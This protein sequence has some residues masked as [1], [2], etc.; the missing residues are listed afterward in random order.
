M[1]SDYRKLTKLLCNG[2]INA[3]TLFVLGGGFRPPSWFF[4]DSE[5]LAQAEGLRVFD[6]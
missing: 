2:F 5:K 6:F 1:S 4:K 3:L